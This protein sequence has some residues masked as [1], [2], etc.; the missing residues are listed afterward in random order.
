MNDAV[1]HSKMKMKIRARIRKTG[2]EETACVL[3]SIVPKSCIYMMYTACTV[4][5]GNRDMQ[6]CECTSMIKLLK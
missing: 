2:K 5:E 3:I 4:N 1:M 6:Y